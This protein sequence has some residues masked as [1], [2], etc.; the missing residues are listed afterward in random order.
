[1][2]DGQKRRRTKKEKN[3]QKG[4]RICAQQGKVHRKCGGIV[5]ILSGECQYA[6]ANIRKNSLLKIRI[7]FPDIFPANGKVQT[8][9]GKKRRRKKK[10][11]RK[12]DE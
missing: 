9:D 7:Y 12:M 3:G 10:M 1:V 2:A 8:R 6:N 11:Q 5:P 4:R